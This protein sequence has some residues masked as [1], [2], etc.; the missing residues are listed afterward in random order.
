[1]AIP[2]LGSIWQVA[3]RVEDV[4][5]DVEK[6]TQGLKA[7]RDDMVLL[8]LRVTALEGREELLIE[9]TRTAAAT[10]ASGTVTTH[11]VDMSRR[12]G[13]L[14]AGQGRRAHLE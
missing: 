6:L 3:R 2:V 8:Q 7:L 10:A 9:R 1:M 5:R 14:E 12:I 11:L 4:F 13:V